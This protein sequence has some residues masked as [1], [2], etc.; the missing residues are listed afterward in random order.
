MAVLRWVACISINTTSKDFAH[1]SFNI[2]LLD[3]DEII[4]E[5]TYDSIENLAKGAKARIEFS[6]D[7]D[8]EKTEVVA[9]YWE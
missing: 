1:I 8:F 7:K 6:T 2:N 9:D 5:S 4:V 3:K